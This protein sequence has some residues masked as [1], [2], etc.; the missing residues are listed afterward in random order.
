MSLPTAA[1]Q[2]AA[3]SRYRAD[4]TLQGLLTG[5]TS[6]LWN[7]YDQMGVPTNTAFPYVVVFPIMS[8]QGM[9]FAFGT[10]AV[11]SY[12]Q[13]S[14]FTQTGASGGFS[15]AR[16]IVKRVYD[17]THKQAFNLSGS[18]F[19]QFLLLFDNEQEAPQQDGITQAIHHRYRLGTQG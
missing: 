14:V 18:G 3:I 8:Q 9:A 13:V 12:M 11:D 16:A 15:Q 7:I 4:T 19:N 17:I 1:I 5:A 2:T 6:P 10:D